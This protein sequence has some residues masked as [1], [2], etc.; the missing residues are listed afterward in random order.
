MNIHYKIGTREKVRIIEVQIIEVRL[1]LDFCWQDRCLGPNSNLLPADEQS[2]M[3]FFALLADNLTHSS[4][5]IYLLA[6]RSLH[7]DNS[8]P[9]PLVSCLQLQR[10]LSPSTS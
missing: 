8:L 4:I 7:I 1:Y 6:V 3:H 2:L 10:L 9:N 5:K